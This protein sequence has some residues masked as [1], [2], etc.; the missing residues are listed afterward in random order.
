M[1]WN[2]LDRQ[3]ERRAGVYGEIFELQRAIASRTS[4]RRDIAAEDPGLRELLLRAGA[5][6]LIGYSSLLAFLSWGA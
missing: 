3:R 5:A 1:G 6:W 2:L 4:I